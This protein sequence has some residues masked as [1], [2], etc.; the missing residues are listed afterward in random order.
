ML[1]VRVLVMAAILEVSVLLPISLLFT[2]L[3]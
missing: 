1:L 2:H 3:I